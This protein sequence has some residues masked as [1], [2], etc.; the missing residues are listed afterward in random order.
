MCLRTYKYAM[1]LDPYLKAVV[2][3]DTN[4]EFDKNKFMSMFHSEE[5]FGWFCN[6]NKEEQFTDSDQINMFNTK[7]LFD[8]LKMFLL[9]NLSINA[10]LSIEFRKINAKNCSD[11]KDIS[12]KQ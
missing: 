4:C 7:R 10:E 8:G 6:D 1:L 11:R 3:K 5:I 2:Q 12:S 9:S